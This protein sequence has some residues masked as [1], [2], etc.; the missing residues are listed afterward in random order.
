MVGG[1][2]CPLGYLRSA[3]G[4]EARHVSAVSSATRGRASGITM[5][6][7]CASIE[8]PTCTEETRAVGKWLRHAKPAAPVG[9]QARCPIGDRQDD[10]NALPWRT[11]QRELS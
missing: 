8:A 1:Q 7:A 2:P 3:D 9:Y 5:T 4:R 10:H 11:R 6:P